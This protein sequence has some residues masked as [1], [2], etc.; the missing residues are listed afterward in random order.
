MKSIEQIASELQGYD[1]QAL[2]ADQVAAFLRQLAPGPARAATQVL[3]VIEAA[4]RVVAGDVVSP[5]SVPPP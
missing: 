1:P 3:P 5:G 4:D 2:S